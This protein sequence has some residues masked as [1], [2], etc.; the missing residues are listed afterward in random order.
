MLNLGDLA[1]NKT[2]TNHSF[3]V[4]YGLVERDRQKAKQ[5][6]IKNV[7]YNVTVNFMCQLDWATGW[8]DT[9][10]IILGVSAG[11]F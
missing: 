6:K 1:V 4:C 11:V 3:P 10:S 8:P 9:W 5:V 7:L 2:S